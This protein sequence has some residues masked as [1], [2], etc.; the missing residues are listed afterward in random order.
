MTSPDNAILRLEGLKKYYGSKSGPLSKALGLGKRR[1]LAVDGVDL[2][3]ARGEVLG[4]VGESGCGKST[5]GKT[6]LLL[7]DPTEGRIIFDG[8][9]LCDLPREELRRIRRRMQMVFQDPA[10]SLNPRKSVADI[11]N[12]SIR[13][14]KAWDLKSGAEDLIQLVGLSPDSLYRYPHQFSGGQKQRIGIARALAS[15]PEVIIADEPVASLDVSVQAQILRLMLDLQQSFEL[16][17]IFI[18]HDL[19]VV[20]RISDIVA[21]MYMGKIVEQ[22]SAKEVVESPLH[23]YTRALISAI[24]TI[25]HKQIRIVLSGEVPDPANPPSGCRFH[26][27]CFEEKISECAA[28]EPALTEVSAGRFTACHLVKGAGAG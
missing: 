26:P 24:P 22:G 17:Y 8:R 2:S 10:A 12:A 21:V 5:L 7:E 9:N 27:R 23:P 16:A 6:A 4:L 19:N 11:L 28:L 15:G 18:S 1:L 3:L 14:S 20:R 25:H 13:L